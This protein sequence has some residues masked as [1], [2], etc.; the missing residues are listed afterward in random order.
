MANNETDHDLLTGMRTDVRWIKNDLT[1]LRSEIGR[2]KI[3]SA[4]ISAV[5]AV[6]TAIVAMLGIQ[7]KL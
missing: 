1:D 4:S 5:V 6:I 2:I 3:M 7:G